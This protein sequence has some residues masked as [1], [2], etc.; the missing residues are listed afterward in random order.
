MANSLN[1]DNALSIFTNHLM[2]A[3]MHQIPNSLIFN[4]HESD[5]S[6]PRPLIKFSVYFNPVVSLTCIT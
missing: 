2:I 3:Y 4:F 1:L 6:E 5:Q